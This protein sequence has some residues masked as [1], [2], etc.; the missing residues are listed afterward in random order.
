MPNAC[1]RP[2]SGPLRKEGEGYVLRTD[3][4]EV[5]LNATVLEGIAAGAGPE[6]GGFSGF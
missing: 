1:G 4:E 6:E 3:V 2:S 5:V